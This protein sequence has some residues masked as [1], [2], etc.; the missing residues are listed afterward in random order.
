MTDVTFV[1]SGGSLELLYHS[2]VP[3]RQNLGSGGRASCP[4]PSHSVSNFVPELY[5]VCG[6]RRRTATVALVRLSRAAAECAYNSRQNACLLVAVERGH[7]FVADIPGALDLLR[8]LSSPGCTKPVRWR[9]SAFS[10]HRSHDGSARCAAPRGARR[11]HY[12]ARVS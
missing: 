5:I 2:N 10:S 7:G 9:C 4:Y 6:E 12:A 8:S 11:S 3:P 1:S